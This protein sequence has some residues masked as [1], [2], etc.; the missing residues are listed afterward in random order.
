MNFNNTKIAFSMKSNGDL[1]NAL[2]LYTIIQ[3]PFVVKL[4]KVMA[5]T[6][7]AIRFPIAWA[8][9]PTL[10]RQFVGGESLQECSKL[11]NLLKEYNV[12][13]VLD[14]SAEGGS[15]QE[16]INNAFKETMRSIEFAK[17]DLSI[18]Y[19]VFKPTAMVNDALLNKAAKAFDSLSQQEREEIEKFRERVLALCQKAYESNVRI[20]IDAEHYATQDLIDKVAEEAMERYNSKRAI[21]FQTLQ[22]YRV[23]RLDYLKKIHKEAQEKNYIPGI[24]F[25]RGAYMEE[26]RELAVKNGYLDPIHP[27][28]EATDNCYDSGL[29]YVMEHIDSFELFSGTHNYNSNILLAKLI[30][31]KGIKKDDQRIFFSQ[32]YGMSDN[33]TFTLAEAGFNVCKYVPYAPVKEVLPYLIRRA[34]ENTSMAGQTSRELQ[35]IKSEIVRRRK[36]RS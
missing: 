15:S 29:K 30:E 36:T 28:K 31:E 16:H 35:L 20:L 23:D 11:A 27:T 2:L 17:G 10:Y 24:K 21:V 7:M 3:R 26:E 5:N 14:Y 12:K 6:A 32:L 1:R 4:A 9:K 25:V 13:S 8:V 19:T 33:I 22:M 34:E 18:P